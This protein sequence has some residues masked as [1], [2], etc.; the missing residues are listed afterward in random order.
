VARAIIGPMAAS[1]RAGTVV[2]AA[3]ALSGAAGCGGGA[4]DTA[5]ST[6]TTPLLTQPAPIPQPVP[7]PP[8]PRAVPPSVPQVGTSTADASAKRVIDAWLARL[9]RGDV[10]GAA[11]LVAD[12]SHVQ[13][14]TPVL[15]LRTRA[16]RRAWVGSFPCG[17]LARSYGARRGYTIVRFILTERRGGNCQ[18]GAG[19]GARSAVE[20]RRGLIVSWYRLPDE[21]PRLDIGPD[22]QT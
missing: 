1:R 9:R 19:Q 14:G 22:Q 11:A 17:A 15:T 20:V 13:N 12:G 7:R 16:A 10:D 4:K 5:S 6:P 21:E 18:G 3:V 2:L 8:D